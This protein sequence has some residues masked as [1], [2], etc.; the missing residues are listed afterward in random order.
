MW[1]WRV[2]KNHLQNK[3]RV[4]D[5]EVSTWLVHRAFVQAP[6]HFYQLS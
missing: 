4:E 1:K 5:R 3:Q 2:T 6:H